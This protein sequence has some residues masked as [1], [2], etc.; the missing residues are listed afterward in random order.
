MS[1]IIQRLGMKWESQGKKGTFQ[2]QPPFLSDVDAFLTAIQLSK[3]LS[4]KTN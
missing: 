2:R 4:G 1:C 3:S